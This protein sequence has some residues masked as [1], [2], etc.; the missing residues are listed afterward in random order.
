[1]ESETSVFRVGFDVVWILVAGVFS[2]DRKRREILRLTRVSKQLYIWLAKEHQIWR[3]ILANDFSFT[4][5]PLADSNTAE[6]TD[7]ANS[8]STLSQ[9]WGTLTAETHSFP[10][11]DVKRQCGLYQLFLKHLQERVASFPLEATIWAERL[12]EPFKKPR[13]ARKYDADVD[14]RRRDSPRRRDDK[15][16]SLRLKLPAAENPDRGLFTLTLSHAYEPHG[17]RGFLH[18][19][20]LKIEGTWRL[21]SR[22]TM[23][24]YAKSVVFTG[25]TH[26]ERVRNSEW[27]DIN[28]TFGGVDASTSELDR[29]RLNSLEELELVEDLT[30]GETKKKDSNWLDFSKVTNF[31]R[32]VFTPTTNDAQEKETVTADSTEATEEKKKEKIDPLPITGEMKLYRR[33]DHPHARNEY[34]M[35]IRLTIAYNSR[36]YGRTTFNPPD[37][38]CSV[39]S[40]QLYPYGIANDFWKGIGVYEWSEGMMVW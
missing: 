26:G 30:I 35:R 20:T 16:A 12:Y 25:D 28:R 18:R 6:P 39:S 13:E 9:L 7:D 37:L 17:P 2:K 32:D 14:F 31:V 24:C 23:N 33:K 10:P 3:D 1:M 4:A 15:E 38:F 29:L 19:E 27:Q 5:P 22:M 21:P 40:H 11:S 36:H 8:K 34:V